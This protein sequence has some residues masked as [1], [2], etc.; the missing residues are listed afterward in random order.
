[1]KMKTMPT[2]YFDSNNIGSSPN[3]TETEYHLFIFL[4]LFCFCV[5]QS[6][7]VN[8]LTYIVW[9]SIKHFSMQCIHKCQNY[10]YC[11]GQ[12]KSP[13]INS[14]NIEHWMIVWWCNTQVTSH[15]LTS[16]SV[17]ISKWFYLQNSQGISE[18]SSVVHKWKLLF[19]AV[20][21]FYL[22][23]QPNWT[24]VWWIVTLECFGLMACDYLKIN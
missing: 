11:W 10:Y 3:K 14:H 23:R 21:P 22:W 15:S 8:T 7:I 6:K 18:R 24:W 19:N 20:F 12:A 2:H 16:V 5:S 13:Q 17:Y 4:F 1:M 9:H